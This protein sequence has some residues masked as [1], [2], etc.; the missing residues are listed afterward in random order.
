MVKCE[1]IKLRCAVVEM[2]NDVGALTA[3]IWTLRRRLCGD[4]SF[5]QDLMLL[6]D[7]ISHVL[8][9]NPYVL[10][11]GSVVEGWW[12]ES[13]SQW[14]FGTCFR[15]LVNTPHKKSP[16]RSPSPSYGRT[17]SRNN[18]KTIFTHI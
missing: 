1:T 18:H 9:S 11:T 3:A 10:R 7:R 5:P 17:K 15:V 13:L 2:T 14:M 12:S 16:S 4:R 8:F 6:R